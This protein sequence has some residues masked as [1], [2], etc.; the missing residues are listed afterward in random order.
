[1]KRK[2]FYAPIGEH[3]VGIYI[4]AD[5]MEEAIDKIKTEFKIS[6]GEEL[7]IDNCHEV[8]NYNEERL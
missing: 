7:I 3:G 6:F 5:T 8:T 4:K 2:L 1:M